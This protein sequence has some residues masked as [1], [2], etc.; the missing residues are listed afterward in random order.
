L[1]LRLGQLIDDA[2][3]YKKRKHPTKG[4]KK[5]QGTCT[6]VQA[7][8]QPKRGGPPGGKVTTMYRTLLQS[9]EAYQLK[10]GEVKLIKLQA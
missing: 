10:K 4:E 8:K 5:K 3:L 6:K 9:C 2:K 1:D 7:S